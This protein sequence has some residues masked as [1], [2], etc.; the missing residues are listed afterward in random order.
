MKTMYQQH[1]LEAFQ[2]K[3]GIKEYGTKEREINF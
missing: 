1:S 3:C 2:H